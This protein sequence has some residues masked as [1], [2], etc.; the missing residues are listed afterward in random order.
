MLES[1]T[2]SITMATSILG[3]ELVCGSSVPVAA[4]P[5]LTSIESP[6]EL[7][8]TATTTSDMATIGG[9]LFAD[10]PDVLYG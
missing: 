9:L 10:C 4:S 8:G 1:P 3:F 2:R 6:A 7:V 5:P